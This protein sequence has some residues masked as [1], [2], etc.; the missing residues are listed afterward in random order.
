MGCRMPDNNRRPSI[1][2]YMHYEE[3]KQSGRKITSVPGPEASPTHQLT[4]H[5]NNHQIGNR[6][7]QPAQ[8]A[9]KPQK[10]PKKKFH[11]PRASRAPK[12]TQAP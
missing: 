8:E 4:I 2:G 10:V 9:R 6:N 3:R 12:A 11:M 5:N 7:P 1:H